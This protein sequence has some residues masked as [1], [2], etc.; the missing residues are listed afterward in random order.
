ME[1]MLQQTLLCLPASRKTISEA[2]EKV[3]EWCCPGAGDE[4]QMEESFSNGWA[5][6]TTLMSTVSE[7]NHFAQS[8]PS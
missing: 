1:V 5:E 3:M 7:G 6:V 8:D 4:R 2:A